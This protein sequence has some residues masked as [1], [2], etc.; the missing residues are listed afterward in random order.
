M[1]NKELIKELK[2]EIISLNKIVLTLQKS[3]RQLQE[4]YI[5]DYKKQTKY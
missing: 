1:K 2:Q 4:I 3:V 5:E